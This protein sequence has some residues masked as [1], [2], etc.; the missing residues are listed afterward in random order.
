[1]QGVFVNTNAQM[2]LISG[3][4]ENRRFTVYSPADAADVTTSVNQTLLVLDKTTGLYNGVDTIHWDNGQTWRRVK[5][6][7]WQFHM[8]TRRAYV[9]LT[10]VAAQALMSFVGRAMALV[11]AALKKTE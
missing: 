6:S 10:F 9:P 7:G 11:K 8:L 4:G 3:N 5:M 1:M 2:F